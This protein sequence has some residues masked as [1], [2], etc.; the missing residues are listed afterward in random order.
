MIIKYLDEFGDTN[1]QASGN[2]YVPYDENHRRTGA[3]VREWY[4]SNIKTTKLTFAVTY[5]VRKVEVEQKRKPGETDEEVEM[6]PRQYAQRYM[7]VNCSL[8]LSNANKEMYAMARTLQPFERVDIK[9]VLITREFTN[10]EGQVVIYDEVRLE[11][12]VCPNRMAAMLMGMQPKKRVT[13]EDFKKNYGAETK[14]GALVPAR[15]RPR[16][17]PE[18][19]MVMPDDDYDF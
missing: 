14:P 16:T 10:A 8:P 1:I 13:V 6:K 4:D 9:G 15:P 11:S 3:P 18:T 17:E 2:V 7:M 19:E 12:V 5:R